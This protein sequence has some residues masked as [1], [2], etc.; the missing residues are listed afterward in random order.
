[1]RPRFH[2]DIVRFGSRSAA[3]HQPYASSPR[4][5]HQGPTTLPG[6]SVK[7]LQ[8][9]PDWKGMITPHGEGRH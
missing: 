3:P 9:V 1:M 4:I 2:E 6:T 7:R 5:R 8:L